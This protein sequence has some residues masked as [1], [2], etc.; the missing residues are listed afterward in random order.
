[1]GLNYSNGYPLGDIQPAGY[2]ITRGCGVYV[3]SLTFS[4]APAPPSAPIRNDSAGLPRFLDL[5]A[6]CFVSLPIGRDVHLSTTDPCQSLASLNSSLTQGYAGSF[7]LSIQLSTAQLEALEEARKADDLR[8][9]IRFDAL[10]DGPRS[11]H[12]SRESVPYRIPRSDWTSSLSD[13]GFEDIILVEVRL[14]RAKEGSPDS[15]SVARFLAE[16]RSHYAAG[17]WPEAVAACRKALDAIGQTYG[18]PTVPP[19]VG[20]LVK[21]AESMTLDARSNLVRKTVLAF[22][23]PSAHGDQTAASIEWSRVDAQYALA[24]VASIAARLRC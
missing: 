13:A 11:L 8:L 10:L 6:T 19:E 2:R 1:M 24:I 4:F 7:D 3:F 22:C 15:G 23:H 9:S 21:H 14:P 20:A 17:N 16:S 5:R 18:Q 12:N